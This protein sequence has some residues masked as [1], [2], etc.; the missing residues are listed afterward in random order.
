[1]SPR[2]RRA[3]SETA[4]LL[5]LLAVAFSVAY[6]VTKVVMGDWSR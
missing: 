5:F 6:V 2:P 3:L 4:V 1:M